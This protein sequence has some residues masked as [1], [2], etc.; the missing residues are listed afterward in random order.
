MTT[1]YRVTPK[2]DKWIVQ[3]VSDRKTCGKPFIK[4]ID[5]KN[6]RD[7][8]IQ[9][10]PKETSELKVHQAY[11]DFAAWKD[12]QSGP[13]KKLGKKS[14]AVYEYEHRLRI[15]PFME[16]KLLS[17]FKLLDMEAYLIKA[18]DNGVPYRTLKSSVN[19]FKTFIRRMKAIGNNPCTD[20]L[21][22]IVEDFNYI[23][24]KDMGSIKTPEVE[25]LMDKEIET[26]LALYFRE[27]PFKPDSAA[28]FALFYIM[29]STGLRIA[30]IQGIKKA[31]V[32]ME[33][34]LLHIKGVYNQAE[35]GFI[36]KTKNE[37]SLRP[38]S[39]DENQLHFFNWYLGYL[40]KHY[41]YNVY[42]LPSP[43]T[44]GPRG[45]KNIRKL[46]WLAYARMGLAEIRMEGGYP[47]VVNS[48]LKGAPTKTF[49]HKFCNA[50]IE[51]MNSEE[52]L[53]ANFVT[54][55]A[56]HSQLETTGGIYGKKR[57]RIIRE[58]QEQ[59]DA[60]AAVKARVLNTS[61]LPIPK[62]ISQK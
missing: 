45:Y 8:L 11:K 41:K 16:N 40:N 20:V 32:D 39:L 14:T 17:D 55:S 51:A 15:V 48:I 19:F 13:T 56:G 31:C 5:A 33:K 47:V 22:F 6:F 58:T 12:T 26:I 7:E 42:L 21:E 24:P 23:L 28:T 9:K 25:M 10:A 27:A 52:L 38:L 50:L 34:K 35:G 61:I 1:Q 53:S 49:R 30:E 36:N 43:R 2:R 54:H 57:N 59:R 4:Q 29:F 60:R 18:F 3:R 46:V 44:D 62:L 37:A